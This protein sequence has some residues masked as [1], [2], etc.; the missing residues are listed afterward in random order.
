LRQIVDGV[1]EIGIGYV[2]VHLVAADG[3]LVMVDTGLPRRAD[4]IA[5]AVR[6]SGHDLSDVHTILLT[7]RHPDHVGSL[8]ELKRRTGAQVVAHR[9]DVPVITGDQPQPLHSVMMRLT[10]PLMKTE[11]AP[12]DRMLDGDGSTGIPGIRA[13]HTPGHTAGHVSFLVDRDGGVLFAGDAAG[14]M[15]GR[16]RPPPRMTTIDPAAA[17]ASIGRLAELDF[18]VAVFGHGAAVSGDAVAR[19]RDLAAKTR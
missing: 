9:A 5:A 4:R 8:A 3:G 18:R 11:P 19:F 16:L 12:V 13:I 17:S 1:W 6:S 10:A 7:H 15:F 14:T 2:H